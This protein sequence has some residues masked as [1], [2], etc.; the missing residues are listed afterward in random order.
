MIPARPGIALLVLGL[1]AAAPALA[2]DRPSFRVSVEAGASFQAYNQLRI[3][4][5]TGTRFDYDA[6][7]GSPVSPFFRIE[8]EAEP[9]ARHGFRVAYQYLRNEGTGVL[10]GPTVFAGQVFAPGARTAGRYSFDAFRATWRYTLIE[11]QEWRV[12]LGATLLLRD[13]EV[14][15]SQNGRIARD[16][17]VGLVPLLHA[18]FDARLAPRLTLS[19]EVDG[20][21]FGQGYAVDLGLRLGYDLDRNWQVSGGW[22]MLAGGADT[23]STFAFARFHALTAGLAYRF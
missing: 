11:A 4:A 12:R 19:G 17:D 14:R 9:W 20:L 10:P 3:P 1:L 6:L 5:R 16:E 2:A 21:G 8:A 15:L 7:T 23:R 22:R 18:A 13:A